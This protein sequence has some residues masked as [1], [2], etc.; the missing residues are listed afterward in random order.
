MT[1]TQ[2]S[3][4]AFGPARSTVEGAPLAP[5]EL[6]DIDAYFRASLYMCLGMIY[7]RDNPLLRRPLTADNV[8][9]R[10]LGHWGSD[11]GMS[12]IY[13]HLK[14]FDQEV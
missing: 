14:P 9:I 5:E 7:L 1:E 12:F 8:K 11:P 13:I 4:S 2:D 6:R 10:L 3:I